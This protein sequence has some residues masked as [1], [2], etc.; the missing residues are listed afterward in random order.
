MKFRMAPNSL[1]AVLLRSPWWISGALALGFV[2][3]S[4]ALLP[5]EYWVF[6]AMGGIP[7]FVICCIAAWR[8]LRAPGTGRI[9]AV[10][11]AVTAM[12]WREFAD[13]LAQAWQREGYTVERLQGAADF[14]LTR[15]GRTT[16]VAARR[17]KA[18]RPGVDALEELQTA[19]RARDASGGL[20][21]TLGELSDNAQRYARAQQ[22][23]LL[24][25]ADLARLIRP[26]R[27]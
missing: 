27:N 21:V 10:R 5:A 2:A 3:A 23:G 16:L 7:M 4:R 20:Y 26:A 17:W 6:G 25:A 19:V 8:Q 12:A 24:G 11:Q 14:A 1:F 13:A 22:I 9:E 18:A 15:G